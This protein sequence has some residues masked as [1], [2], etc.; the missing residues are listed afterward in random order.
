VGVEKE[1]CTALG[2]EVRDVD[3]NYHDVPIIS[4]GG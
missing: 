1:R 4:P 2:G 3:M